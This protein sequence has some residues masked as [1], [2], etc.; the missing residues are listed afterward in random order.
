MRE[1]SL[2]ARPQPNNWTQLGCSMCAV[3][4]VSHRLVAG[5]KYLDF[6][7]STRDSPKFN[8]SYSEREERD[9]LE[10]S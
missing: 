1:M 8:K 2:A 5:I 4:D 6:K 10:R 7:C 9:R 3:A